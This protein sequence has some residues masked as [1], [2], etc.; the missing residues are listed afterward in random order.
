MFDAHVLQ[1]LLICTL[2]K[3]ESIQSRRN[4][5]LVT[6]SLRKCSYSKGSIC[7]GVCEW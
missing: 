6:P 3:M 7:D 2:V 5:S 4:I 1:V